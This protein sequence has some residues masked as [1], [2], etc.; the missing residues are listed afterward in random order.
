MSAVSCW[1]LPVTIVAPPDGLQTRQD[2]VETG[3]QCLIDS[4]V[5]NDESVVK[6]PIFSYIS[7][8]YRFPS[9]IYPRYY[10]YCCYCSARSC[11]VL[12]QVMLYDF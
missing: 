12:L 3:G 9:S 2:P 7:Q 1:L 10:R 4:E 5:A 8:P 6:A 11:Q